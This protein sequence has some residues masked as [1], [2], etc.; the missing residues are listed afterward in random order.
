[1]PFKD[2]GGL[3]YAVL[4]VGYSDD[5]HQKLAQ[6]NP[7]VGEMVYRKNWD[8]SPP[9]AYVSVES[10]DGHGFP[11]EKS[12]YFSY[13][14]KGLVKLT[15]KNAALLAALLILCGAALFY[16]AWAVPYPI[17]DMNGD[18]KVDMRD[19]VQVAF[20]Y[21]SE[22]G[23]SRFNPRCDFNGDGVINDYDVNAIK[24]YFG[25]GQLSV[26]ELMGYRLMGQRGPFLIMG[27]VA[28]VFGL[29]LLVYALI[30]AK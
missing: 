15:K 7:V 25:Q 14:E 13:G 11:N 26:I 16:Y 9:K 2:V 3:Y 24:D 1:M 5:I 22:A 28:A 20:A 12:A 23:D 29:A 21:G 17:R 4:V 27:L 6:F 19:I 8:A 10:V 30:F 18:G